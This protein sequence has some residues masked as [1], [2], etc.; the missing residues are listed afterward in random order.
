MQSVGKKMG[1]L[2]QAKIASLGARQKPYRVSDGDGLSLLVSVVGGKSWQGRYKIDNKEQIVSLGRYPVINLKQAREDWLKIRVDRAKG[3]D[4]AGERR[5]ARQ[6]RKEV[7]AVRKTTFADAWEKWVEV[8]SPKWGESRI[9]CVKS[10]YRNYFEK[11][12]GPMPIDSPD[13]SDALLGILKQAGKDG[14]LTLARVML[15]D[16]GTFAK[17]CVAAKYITASFTVGLNQLIEEAPATKNH[18]AVTRPDDVAKLLTA[19]FTYDYAEKTIVRDALLFSAL[20]FV[21]PNEIREAKWCD[22]DIALKEWRFSTKTRKKEGLTIIVPLSE[23]AIDIL[24]RISAQGRRNE[25]VF[26]QHN[27]DMPLT[28]D[29]MR[30]PL[31]KM[32][33]AE[34]HSLHGFRAM[35][36]TML[37]ETFKQDP[38]YL[39]MQLG[40]VVKDHLGNAYNRAAF[41]DERQRVMKLWSDYIYKFEGAK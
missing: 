15:G 25:Y 36:R 7:I 21:R 40:H 38:K 28:H 23:Q 31:E 26:L 22:I 9:S 29:I 10:R 18:A 41:L 30:L 27:K 35:A 2:T 8:R 37:E 12:L 20:T 34:K 14:K 3:I 19:I 6:A 11:D 32:G 5:K 16:C 24:T 1:K 13:L 4:P 33:Y 17:Y 39:E